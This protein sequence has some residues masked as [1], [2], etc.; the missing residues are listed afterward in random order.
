MGIE[1]IIP[2][3]KGRCP[4]FRRRCLFKIFPGARLEHDIFGGMSPLC[5]PITPSLFG[6]EGIEPHTNCLQNSY[7]YR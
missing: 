4:A 1:P 3:L 6:T 7:F 2:A 5:Y